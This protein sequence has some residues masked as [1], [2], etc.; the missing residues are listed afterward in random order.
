MRIKHIF[1]TVFTFLN[2]C[3]FFLILAAGTI[4]IIQK[5]GIF[6]IIAVL[7]I[8]MV[9]VQSFV[10][11]FIHLEKLLRKSKRKRT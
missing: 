8:L 2:G 3:L 4:D 5:S 9:T 6:G 11:A 7:A 1:I 10:T